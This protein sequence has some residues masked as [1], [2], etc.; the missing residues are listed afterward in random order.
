[1]ISSRAFEKISLC[2]AIIFTAPI[3]ILLGSYI[4]NHEAPE[5]KP[6]IGGIWMSFVFWMG[7]LK[8][9]KDRKEE[10][11]KRTIKSNE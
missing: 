9:R 4:A 5:T 3:V 8:F 7:Y 6:I 1:M 10:D 2:L 11:S